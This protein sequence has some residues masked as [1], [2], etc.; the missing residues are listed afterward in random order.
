MREMQIIAYSRSLN[1][2]NIER[3][4]RDED[5]IARAYE[6]YRASNPRSRSATG[7]RQVLRLDTLSLL[8]GDGMAVVRKV[9]GTELVEVGE[10]RL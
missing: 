3:I 9:V 10:V 8:F 1:Q 5:R 2:R 4:E 7:C 6:A